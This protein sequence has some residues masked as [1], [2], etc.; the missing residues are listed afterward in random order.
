MRAA[1]PVHKMARMERITKSVAELH[2]ENLDRLPGFACFLV[3]EDCD[4]D[5]SGGSKPVTAFRRRSCPGHQ[6]RDGDREDEQ[7]DA[8][9][10]VCK[11]VGDVGQAAEQR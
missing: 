1:F 3:K 10:S 9:V 8:S 4:T 7:Q 5:W 11:A 6:E 2:A